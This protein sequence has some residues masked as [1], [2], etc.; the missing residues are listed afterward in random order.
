[1]AGGLGGEFQGEFAAGP[2]LGEAGG[3]QSVVVGGAE[4]LAGEDGPAQLEVGVVL[5]GEADAAEDLDGVLG[6]GVRDVGCGGGGERGDEPARPGV[7]SGGAGRVPGEG[8]GLFEADEHVG[9]EVL[10]RLERSDGPPEL[11]PY[12]GVFGGGAQAEGGGSA[13]VGGEQDRCQ[14]A[15]E[16]RVGQGDGPV[17]RYVDGVGAHLGGGPGRVGAAVR[18]DGEPGR[19]GVQEE[20]AL[21]V[22]R[23]GGQQDQVGRVGAEDGGCD[24]VEPVPARD[25]GGGEGAGAEGEGGGAVARGELPER[26]GRVLRPGLHRAVQHGGGEHGGEVRAGEHGV[27]RLFQDDREVQEVPAPAAVR[28]G[29][30]D[31]GEPLG[32]E[33]LPV[34]GAGAGG[35][36][37]LCVEEF[38]NLAGRHGSGQ[39]PP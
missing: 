31:A 1:M 8:A 18:A 5:P 19:P 24:A 14:V 21:A 13:G 27:R 26:S 37:A 30:V 12:E 20:P 6:A 16:R 10:D 29:Q 15:G 23:G 17:R 4:E 38:A 11:L 39:P 34:G 28:L 33:P 2:A 7:L 36:R 35:G 32:G 22:G 9:A 25:G 3:P